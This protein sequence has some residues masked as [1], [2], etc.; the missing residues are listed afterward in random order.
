[1][2]RLRYAG[3]VGLC[4]ALLSGCIATGTKV[5]EGRLT[6]LT[7]GITTYDACVTTFGP[8]TSTTLHPDKSRV[9]LYRYTQTQANPLNFVPVAGMFLGGTTAETTEVTLFFNPAGRLVSYT[10]TAGQDRMGTG[11]VS[12]SKQ[13]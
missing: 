6:E 11:L 3:G 8:P 9:V 7:P 1:M 2:R 13:R 10:S 12:G 4:V 5:D